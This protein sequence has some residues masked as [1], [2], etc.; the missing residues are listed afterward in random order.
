MPFNVNERNHNSPKTLLSYGPVVLSSKLCSV[1]SREDVYPL[2]VAY[3]CC[4]LVFFVRYGFSV[5]SFMKLSCLR[6]TDF[7]SLAFH[8]RSPSWVL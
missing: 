3:I 1:I 6:S 7:F 5:Y 8:A 4:R 2:L